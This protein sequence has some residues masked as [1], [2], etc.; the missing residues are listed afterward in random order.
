MIIRFW[1]GW[2][3][4]DNAEAYRQVVS[5]EVLPSIADRGIDGY[6]GAFLVRRDVEDEVEF[7]TLMLFDSLEQVRA[8]GG[9]DYEVAYVP[10]ATR[11]V[12]SRFDERSAHY[13]VLLTPDDTR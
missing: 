12:L 10:P 8:F 3:T 6:Q 13:E 4:P 2:T 11:A 9:A 7:A 1:R 5:T